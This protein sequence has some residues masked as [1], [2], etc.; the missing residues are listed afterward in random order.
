MLITG[1]YSLDGAKAQVVVD[2][3]KK[4]GGDAIAVGGD[5]GADDF[6]E[7]IV[8]AT[9]KY[10]AVLSLLE[11]ESETSHRKYGKLNHIINNGKPQALLSI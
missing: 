8:E 1:I 7:N 9:I 4:A 3:I 2:E 11:N 6:P 10:I 5:V